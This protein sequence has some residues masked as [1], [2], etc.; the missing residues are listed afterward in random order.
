MIMKKIMTIKVK[1]FKISNKKLIK[2]MMIMM[3]H[4]GIVK[5]KSNLKRNLKMTQKMIRKLLINNLLSISI[6]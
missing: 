5:E 4:L 1:K 2:K 6:N 3:T